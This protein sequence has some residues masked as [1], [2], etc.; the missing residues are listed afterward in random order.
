[1][2]NFQTSRSYQ[3]QHANLCV[4]KIFASSL[5]SHIVFQ[6]IFM[7]NGRDEE[8]SH[9]PYTIKIDSHTM[10]GSSHIVA[11][12]DPGD[13]SNFCYIL[14]THFENLEDF[15][16][17]VVPAPPRV[18]TLTFIGPHLCVTVLYIHLLFLLV[19]PRCV[20]ISKLGYRCY[21]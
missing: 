8:G 16:A 11:F 4:R 21:E 17:N 18:R 12:E 13:A 20:S 19:N 1:M 9:G 10:D 15:S 7:H 6:A 2:L 5:L 14:H 3:Q